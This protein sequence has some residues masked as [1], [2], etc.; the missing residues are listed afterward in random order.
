M[1]NGLL[2][3]HTPRSICR[4]VYYFLAKDG[5]SAICEVT[6]NRVYHGVQLGLEVYTLHLQILWPPVAHRQ[7]EGSVSCCFMPHILFDR[8]LCLL[9]CLL[10][11]TS[12]LS[13]C[14]ESFLNTQ[15][16]CASHGG[17]SRYI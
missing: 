8:T 16:S 4:V 15:R 13:C 2:V 6:G 14:N 1:K 17:S 5:H 7:T 10:V 11:C 3:G 9:T 12:F